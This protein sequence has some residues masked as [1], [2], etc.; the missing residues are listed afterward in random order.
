MKKQLGVIGITAILMTIL[1]SGCTQNSDTVFEQ[2]ED[3]NYFIGNWG[4]ITN[5][6][7]SSGF[8]EYFVRIYDF[9]DNRYNYSY[10]SEIGYN[11]Y[12]SNSYGLYEVKDGNLILLNETLVPSKKTTFKYSF[13]YNYTTLTLT[14]K[15]GQ[16]IVYMKG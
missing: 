9:T 3:T 5:T 7:N 13:S 10:Y 11:S 8:T 6:I 14:D 4:N 12:Q 16:S 15:S 2:S 1:L